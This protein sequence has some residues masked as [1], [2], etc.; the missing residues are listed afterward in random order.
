MSSE[1]N[2]NVYGGTFSGPNDF[3]TSDG[4]IT[5]Y[6]TFSQY[7]TITT[8]GSGSITGTLAHG[9]GLQTLTYSNSGQIILAQ[10]PNAT[11]TVPEP[12]SFALLGLAL[13]TLGLMVRRR[14]RK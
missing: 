11:P 7:G 13:P 3:V 10:A 12:S 14:V 5:L 6:G 1:G 4:T 9:G 8:T 2:I